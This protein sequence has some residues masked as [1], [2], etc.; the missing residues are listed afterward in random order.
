MLFDFSHVL[1]IIISFSVTAALAV[2]C[3]RLVKKQKEKDLVLKSAAVLTVVFHFSILYV[4]YLGTGQAKIDSSFLFPIYPCHIA[5]WLLVI[6]A[7]S[8]NKQSEV[9]A[10]VAE[11]TFYLGIVGGIVGILFNEIYSGNP[12]LSDWN[13]LKGLLSH[14]TLFFGCLYLLVGG[15][16]KIRVK[17]TFSVLCGLLFLLLDGVIMIGIFRLAKL[18][19]PNCMYLLENPVPSMSWFNTYMIGIA[20]LLVVFATTAFVERITLP[21][22]ERWYTKLKQFKKQKDER[23]NE[24][25]F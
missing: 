22:E 6:V 7:F 10:C 16:I 2:L 3:R 11:F 17:N 12:N 19:P 23:T 20:G 8:K 13:V 15:Y 5:M 25:I 4:T 24:R 21:K 9:F 1:Y 18:D 14:S